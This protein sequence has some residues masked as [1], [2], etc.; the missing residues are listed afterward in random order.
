MP[1][2][3][4]GFGPFTGLL[5]ERNPSGGQTGKLREAKGVMYSGGGKLSVR[6]GTRTV[7]TL[8]DDAGTPANVTTVCAVVPFNDGALAVAH[9]TTTDKVYLYRLNSTLTAWT[10]SA[11]VVTTASTARP[12]GV[13]WSSI[14]DP[15][16]VTIAEGLGVAYIAHA[17]ALDGTTLSAATKQYTDSTWTIATL[18]SD[19]DLAGGSEDLYFRGV[20][21]FQQHLWGWGFGSGTTAANGY[22]PELA[23]FSKPIFDTAGGLFT[24]GTDSLTLGNRV[25]SQREQIVGAGVA[26]ESLFFGAP[27]QLTRITG[28]G[29]DSWFKQPVDQSHGFVGPKCMVTVGDTLYYWS[30]RGPMRI[31][32]LGA[33]EPLWD[34]VSSTASAVTN[35]QKIVA[36]YDEIR[37]IVSWTYDIGSGVQN[38]LGWDVR[39]D[40]CCVVD[41]DWGQDIWNAGSVSPVYQSTAAATVGPLGAPTS[42]ATSSIG[43]TSATAGWTAGDATSPSRVEIRVQGGSTWTTL[44]AVLSAGVQSYALTGLV[45]STAYEWRVAH[46]KDGITSSYLGPVAGSQFTTLSDA[47]LSPPT[48]FSLVADGG[49]LLSPT[50]TAYWT[51]SGE[52]SVNTELWIAGP[53]VVEPDASDYS[54]SNIVGVGVSSAGFTAPSAGTWWAK[55]R[56]ER[57]GVNSDFTTADSAPLSP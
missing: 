53:D 32:A 3:Q 9:S 55:V 4:W 57:S 37:D 1:L 36:A 27:F 52:S 6:P 40:V 45:A 39:R 43:S 56:H 18:T 8:L 5:Q 25:R 35:P 26:G 48:G 15:P 13:L 22:R 50:A 31:T 30:S 33:P 2:T 14:T 24:G 10:D 19:L 46:V 44:T 7:L 41:D 34:V 54:L 28:Y 11:G 16:D 23:R 17:A 29:R 51:N 21:S 42:A 38:W 12:V 49:G 47:A 20:I